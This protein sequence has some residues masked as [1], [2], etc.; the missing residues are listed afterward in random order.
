M[1][2]KDQ[3]CMLVSQPKCCYSIPGWGK[4]G[5]LSQIISAA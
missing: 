2:L 4:S 1:N 5:G 3:Y